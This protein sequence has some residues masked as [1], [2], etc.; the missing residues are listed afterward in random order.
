MTRG[1]TSAAGLGKRIVLPQTYVGSPRDNIITA[2]KGKFTYGNRHV[3]PHNRGAQSFTDL[4]M[5]N[6][7]NYAI[8]KAACFAYDLLND[9]KEWTHAIAD[10]K[11]WV[12][13]SEDILDKKR[14][15]YRYPTELN[16]SDEQVRNYCLLE[17]Q[18]LLNT[19]G[20]TLKMFLYKTIIARLR[21]EQMIVLAVVSL[22]IASLLLPAGRIA[23]S[24]FVIPLELMENSTCALDKTLQYILGY[25]NQARRNRIFGGMMV[26]LGGDFQQILP[27]I[28]NAKR[29]E[30]KKESEDE[31]TWIEIPKEFLIKSWTFPIEQIVAETYPDFTLRKGDDE[32][33][34]ERAI[35]TPR[36]DYADAI[37]EN[38]FKKLRGAPVTY[39]S[40]DEN[41]KASTDTSD[42]YDL[43]PGLCN[44]TRLI[45]T[46]LAQF[47]IKAKILTGSHVGDTVIIHRIVMSSTK[48]KWPFILKR[49]QI[50]VKPCYAMTINKSQG[51]SLNYVGLYLPNH[52]FNHGQLYVA[53]SRVT[54][55]DGL[56]ILMIKDEDKEFK[57][58]TRN[59]VFREAFNNIS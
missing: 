35:L 33:L 6:K 19:Y 29:L 59:I 7:I 2:F 51:Q 39:N 49:R 34:T 17:I 25:K 41:C 46:D 27:V 20:G 14:K 13:L 22:G 52:V 10:S 16:L 3:V 4:K 54:S 30:L 18:D 53:L 58:H 31:P 36:N 24:R 26:L 55:P 12:R 56:K 5:V 44:E 43:Y 1:D 8:F 15:H 42:Q 57:N 38:M 9:D 48:L 37:D 50:P 11:N 21:S 45:I 47:L 32:Y 23:H 40:A 28:P